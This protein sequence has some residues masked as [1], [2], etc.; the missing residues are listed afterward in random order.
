MALTKDQSGLYMHVD[1]GL[2][3]CGA[4][5]PKSKTERASHCPDAQAVALANSTVSF[6]ADALQDVG[7]R[8]GGREM[9]GQLTKI[10]GDEL[11]RYPAQ[12]TLPAERDVLRS[13]LGTSI[14]AALL[15]REALC[16]PSHIF[17]FCQ[18][19][20]GQRVR[21]WPRVREEGIAM[22]DVVPHLVALVGFPLLDTIIATDDKGET[23]D[24]GDWGIV[25]ADVPHALTLECFRRGRNPG[26]SVV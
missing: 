17:R 9:D 8:V 21:W 25:A 3:M 2:V 11:V 20:E 22:A 5:P 12:L 26:K 18:K 14:W 7:F 1:D 4:E 23:H 24:F 13:V 19:C 15:K 10:F 6:C 16:I